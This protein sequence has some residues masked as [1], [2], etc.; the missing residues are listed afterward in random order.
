[1]ELKEDILSLIKKSLPELAAGELK[2]YIE[3]SE[4]SKKD[5]KV[6]QEQLIDTK[7][8]LLEEAKLRQESETRSSQAVNILLR[9]STLLINERQLE[10]EQLKF[11]ITIQLEELKVK[12]AEKRSDNLFT[13]M[14]LLCK[15]SEAIKM[16]SSFESP[17]N[18]PIG[19]YTDHSGRY[20]TQS[21]ET[22]R[23]VNSTEKES[24][25]KGNIPEPGKV[26]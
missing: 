4:K 17:M 16:F 23:T 19:G 9:E 21:I 24:K 10:L 26:E 3:E 2:N 18:S 5:F 11:K 6:V 1:M 20:H 7:A 13:L 8:K 14:G 12:E 22:G 25:D 15:N